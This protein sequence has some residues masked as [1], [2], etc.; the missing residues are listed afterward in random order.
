MNCGKIKNNTKDIL[1][2]Q[3]VDIGL[4][5]RNISQAKKIIF[6]KQTA[7]SLVYDIPIVYVIIFVI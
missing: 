6:G 2:K 1:G 3:T 7:D 4:W 5:H